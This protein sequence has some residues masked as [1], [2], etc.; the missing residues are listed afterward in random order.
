MRTAPGL[1][2]EKWALMRQL[3]VGE[4]GMAVGLLETT[5]GMQINAGVQNT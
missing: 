4:W 3:H 5:L 1:Q 2:R